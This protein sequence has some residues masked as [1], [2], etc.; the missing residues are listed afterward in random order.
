MIDTLRRAREDRLVSD[1]PPKRSR[2]LWSRF[3][4]QETSAQKVLIAIAALVT[5]VA[6]IVGAGAALVRWLGPTTGEAD[7]TRGLASRDGQVV[8]EQG[9]D[10]ADDLVRAF[11]DS[12][13]DRM[14]LNVMVVA[15]HGVADPQ[16]LFH[17]W[18]NCSGL[19][20]GEPPGADRCDDA[21]FVF[22]DQNPSP[23]SY[24]NPSRV[25]LVG[26]WANNRVTELGYGALGLEFYPVKVTP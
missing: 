16:W 1:Q 18:Y 2:S 3:A 6:T 14:E 12:K 15:Q 19:G 21:A 26:T 13:G 11:I 4:A 5:A 17:L 22:D 10:E 7:E 24:D 25:E 9:S 23:P 8:V 20:R